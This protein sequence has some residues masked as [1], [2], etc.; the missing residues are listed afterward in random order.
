[1]GSSN[2]VRPMLRCLSNV[3]ARLITG[4]VNNAFLFFP[5]QA[6][7][8]NMTGSNN[9]FFFGGW[10]FFGVGFCLFVDGQS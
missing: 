9:A 8:K 2:N 4:G 10:V 5:I 3:A 6:E 1:M 7:T